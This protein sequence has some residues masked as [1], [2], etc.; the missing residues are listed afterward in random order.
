MTSFAFSSLFGNIANE[1]ISITV[2]FLAVSTVLGWSFYGLT[3]LK[4]L[5]IKNISFYPILIAISVALASHFPLIDL[6]ILCDI[7]SALMAL[8][9]LYG[10]WILA[11]VVNKQTKLFLGIKKHTD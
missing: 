10:L 8:P 7:A 4:W 2:V 11:P 6:L 1:F 5:N 9:N 3:C